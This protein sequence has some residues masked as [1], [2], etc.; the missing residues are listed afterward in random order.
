MT[1]HFI[2]DVKASP[3]PALVLVTDQQLNDLVKFCTSPDEFTVI[4]V[5]PTFNLGDFDVTPLMYRHLFLRSERT[6]KSPVF[7]G[8]M[9]IHYRKDFATFLYF[10]STLVGL[11]RDLE[12]LQAFGTDGKKALIDAFSHEFGFAI[13]LLCAIHLRRNVKQHMQSCNFPDEHRRQTLDD[14]FGAKRGSVCIWRAS[15]LIRGLEVL[16]LVSGKPLIEVRSISKMAGFSIIPNRFE[17]CE[18]RIEFICRTGIKAT[19]LGSPPEMFTANAS[20]VTNSVLKS[21][22]DYRREE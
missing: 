15:S 9:L 7:V 3:D 22:V 1:A 5:D 13:Y 17:G 6:R 4:T 18:V 8:P 2:R 19:G 16:C 12:K 21:K 10:A 20:E 14:I 11:R